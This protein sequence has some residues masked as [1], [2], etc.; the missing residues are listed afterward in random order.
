MKDQVRYRG[1][2]STRTCP[3]CGHHEVGITTD[4]GVFARLEPGQRICVLEGPATSARPPGE[5]LPSMPGSGIP[6]SVG[7]TADAGQ[8]AWAPAPLM[9][10]PSLRRVFGVLLPEGDPSVTTPEIYKAA[11]L[12]KL[13]DLIA[14]EEV[15]SRAMLLD[16]YFAAPHI[17]TGF[18]E[19]IARKLWM[20]WEE[21]RA[22][23]LLVASWLDQEE[24]DLLGKACALCGA[25]EETQDRIPDPGRFRQELQALGLSEFLGWVA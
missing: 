7:E 10:M 24:E 12:A 5:S 4:D 14:R 8:V 19:E 23:A 1:V 15:G 11:Y 21:I 25:R 6:E 18:P 17:A 16:E 9:S 20:E 3:A 2:I 22:P 13:I